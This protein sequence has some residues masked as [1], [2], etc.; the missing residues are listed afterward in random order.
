[1][2]GSPESR[3]TLLI[4]SRIRRRHCRRLGER[5]SA[6]TG[7]HS[8]RM[9]S[10]T[11]DVYPV[12]IERP[13]DGRGTISLTILRLRECRARFTRKT[14]GSGIRSGVSGNRVSGTIRNLASP[15]WSASNQDSTSCTASRKHKRGAVSVNQRF[16]WAAGH[17]S[18]PSKSAST[19][20]GEILAALLYPAIR[21]LR[22]CFPCLPK[23]RLVSPPARWTSFSTTASSTGPS[24][25]AL[26]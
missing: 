18:S 16:R 17:P 1:M 2:A 10:I 5:C 21:C 4:S 25:A 6:L 3:I 7:S 13:L 22:N 14:F 24:T 26:I 19:I 9:N 23:T 20:H 8:S 15:T 11:R 12:P